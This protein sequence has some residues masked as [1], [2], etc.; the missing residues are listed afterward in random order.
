MLNIELTWQPGFLTSAWRVE[1]PAGQ[2][3][4]FR[5]I[6][7]WRLPRNPRDLSLADRFRELVGNDLKFLRWWHS[8]CGGQNADA[9]RFALRSGDGPWQIPWE[10]LIAD[11]PAK[12][13]PYI[14]I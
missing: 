4:S 8:E 13:Q 3:F 1:G 5:R 7:L 12:R 10:L 9:V 6:D 14:S 11:V 2:T